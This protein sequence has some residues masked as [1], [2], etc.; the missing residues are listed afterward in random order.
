MGKNRYLKKKNQIS[1][2]LKCIHKC[3]KGMML[4]NPKNNSRMFFFGTSQN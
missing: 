4:I 2:A 1:K 3:C